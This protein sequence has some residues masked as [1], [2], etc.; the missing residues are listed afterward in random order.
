[1]SLRTSLLA[2][3][4]VVLAAAS[5]F[6]FLQ[7]RLT[8]PLLGFGHHPEVSARLE[9][10]LA[11][12]RALAHLD[13]ANE[14]AYRE[15]FAALETLLQR[16][17]V[18]EHS[19]DAII[20]R[21]DTIVLSLMGAV[22]FAVT[23][24]FLWHERRLEAR[25][26]RLQGALADLAAGRTDLDVGERA[27]DV[28]GR[29]ARMIEET[30][31]QMA[32][33]RRRLAALQNLSAWQ[34]AARRHA[35]EMRTPLTGARLELTRLASLV[36]DDPA[37]RRREI[38]QAAKSAGQE[39]ERLGTFAQRFTSF[40]KLPSP[41]PRR[42]DVGALLAEF[43][44]TFESAWPGLAL[45]LVPSEE[46]C[47]A[48]VDRDMLR[49]VLVNLCDNAAQAAGEEGGRLE[50]SFAREGLSVAVRVADDGPGISGA[51]MTRLFEPYTT[52]RSVGEGMGLGLAIS[53]KILLDHGGDLELEA[54]S[55]AGTTFR[56]TLPCEEVRSS[57]ENRP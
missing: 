39:I 51:V 5:F 14:A 15:R 17:Y 8:G 31:R 35:H 50:I 12:Q 40:A 45:V 13:P 42:Q 55:E 56:L 38:E 4:A 21:Y 54:T 6:A 44:A 48:A 9:E 37:A 25:L 20:R 2:V 1:M 11:D 46:P 43:A 32:R 18:V 41:Q 52:T 7:H 29:I 3:A 33:D 36:A 23:G 26:L 57:E 28:V 53:R 10:S 22:V 49:Q 24:A 47:E 19:R 30:S 27:R 34:E 16:L